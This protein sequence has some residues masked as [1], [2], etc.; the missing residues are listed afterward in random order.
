MTAA[1][2]GTIG[3]AKLAAVLV[4]HVILHSS[5]SP[6]ASSRL[7][8]R[9]LM[10][11]LVGVLYH[12]AAPPKSL[13]LLWYQAASACA[14]WGQQK[15]ALFVWGFLDIKCG[16]NAWCQLRRPHELNMWLSTDAKAAI[17]DRGVVLLVFR[18]G[19]CWCLHLPL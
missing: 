18:H 6:A 1:E 10:V 11:V 8:L 2:V 14:L 16:R 19:C 15:A 4:L 5:C 9:L 3:S 12:P 13:L 7:P 17:T